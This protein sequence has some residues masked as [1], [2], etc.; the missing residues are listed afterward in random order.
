MRERERER[1]RDSKYKKDN[2]FNIHDQIVNV[3]NQCFEVLNTGKYIKNQ[4]QSKEKKNGNE[5]K[6]HSSNIQS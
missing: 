4:Q 1:E 6:D 5:V 2:A 3:I